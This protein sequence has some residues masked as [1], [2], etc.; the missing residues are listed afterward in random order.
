MSFQARLGTMAAIEG[1][2]ANA[3]CWVYGA[4]L[5]LEAGIGGLRWWD[6]RR[7][8]QRGQGYVECCVVDRF[9]V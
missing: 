7:R 5:A 4:A 1:A 6:G 8:R 9:T 3:A 2:S